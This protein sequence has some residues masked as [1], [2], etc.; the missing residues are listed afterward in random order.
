MAKYR[1]IERESTI[2]PGEIVYD[3][4]KRVLLWWDIVAE[5]FLRQEYAEK[6]V[7]DLLTKQQASVHSRVIVKTYD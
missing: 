4:E 3:I 6:M 1:I 5:G 7:Q 2:Y